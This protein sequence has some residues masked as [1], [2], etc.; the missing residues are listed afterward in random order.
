MKINNPSNTDVNVRIGNANIGSTV[1]I[2]IIMQY[3]SLRKYRSKISEIP[4]L[5]VFYIPR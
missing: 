1:N 4:N 2:A 3:V 5:F